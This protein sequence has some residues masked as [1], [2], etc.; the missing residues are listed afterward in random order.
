MSFRLPVPGELLFKPLL[1]ADKALGSESANGNNSMELAISECCQ[2][3]QPAY[4]R[5]VSCGCD[6][7][8][9]RLENLRAFALNH[10]RSKI[11]CGQETHGEQFQ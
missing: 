6:D 4:F 9:N 3:L 1:G 11:K 8:Y 10:R 5:R 7:D 2:Q